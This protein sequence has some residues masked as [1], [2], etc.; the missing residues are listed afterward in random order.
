M[1]RRLIQA[2]E[3]LPLTPRQQ[4]AV[5]CGFI[6]LRNLLEAQWEFPGL[7]GFS[8]IPTDS[9]LAF[10]LHFPLFYLALFAV[11]ILLVGWLR[12]D[13][14]KARKVVI[15][16]G[17]LLL[18]PPAF[19]F[20][21]LGRSYHLT[22]FFEGESFARG[23][24]GIA[25]P[26][27]SGI[28]NVSPGQR[29]EVYCADLLV[30]AYLLLSRRG[31]LRGLAGFAATHLVIAGF[32]GLGIALAPFVTKNW[33]CFSHHQIF[34][35]VF[36]LILIVLYAVHARRRFHVPSSIAVLSAGA[37]AVIHCLRADLPL[38]W[39][40]FVYAATAAA[41][42]GSYVLYLSGRNRNLV[43]VLLGAVLVAGARYEAFVFAVFIALCAYVETFSPGKAAK[44]LLGA[45]AALFGLLAGTAIFYSYHAL[46]LT[47]FP[48]MAVVFATG[49]LFFLAQRRW[50]RGVLVALTLCASWAIP[51]RRGVAAFLEETR[52]IGL[53]RQE[54]FTRL[55][56]TS[57]G[58]PTSPVV[59]FLQGTALVNLGYA[60]QGIVHLESIAETTREL[61][62]ARL[63]GYNR[64]RRYADGLASIE[65]AIRHGMIL[66]ESYLEHARQLLL[67]GRMDEAME[68][69]GKA[70]RLG[71]AIA[72]TFVMLGDIR[73]RQGDRRAAIACYRRAQAA[74]PGLSQAYAQEGMALFE[75]GEME[76]AL[77]RF[78]QAVDHDPRD[79]FIH[80]N[81]GVVLRTLGR[82][83]QAQQ[84]FLQALELDPRFVDPYYNLGVNAEVIGRPA[85][86][87]LWYQRAL[88]VDPA[89]TPAQQGLA[90]V[91]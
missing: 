11:L 81:R 29:I 82:N 86:A 48:L 14:L 35:I 46:H 61:A 32:G 17:A 25:M 71:S 47:P 68:S 55:A 2:L 54:D 56:A 69:V 67:L 19:D 6:Y 20:L 9:F 33:L 49:F 62:Y 27:L 26:W 40:P 37:T 65:D 18:I 75:L 39:H 31:W 7:A 74:D 83:D 58:P 63:A 88:A 80:N 91:H 52:A 76:T 4:L 59:R 64:L 30:F 21:V 24:L 66:D 13:P 45:M 43:L 41:L 5:L 22:Y 23:L 16:G 3:Q 73:L 1:I 36:A 57:P 77:S 38:A 50:Q 10:F 28:A 42:I 85:E 72:P 87:A 8:K 60:A 78:D 12:G 90:R 34:I 84:A 53:Y 70:I 44:A 79:A 89:F 51:A 15:L